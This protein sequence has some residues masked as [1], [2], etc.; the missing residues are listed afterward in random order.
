MI[1]EQIPQLD[2]LSVSTAIHIVTTGFTYRRNFTLY[3]N[4]SGFYPAKFIRMS[5]QCS[6]DFINGI[7]F[8][9]L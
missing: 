1:V 6:L 8:F 9:I 7:I 2:K 4:K 5:I 3:R